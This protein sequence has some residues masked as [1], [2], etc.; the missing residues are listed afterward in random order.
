MNKIP[1]NINDRTHYLDKVKPFVGKNLIKVFTGQRRVGKSYLLFQLIQLLQKDK[2]VAI[3]YINKEDLAFS[4]I[5]TAEDL[6]Q[7]VLENKAENQ[8]TYVFIDEIQDIQNFESALRSLLLYSDLDLYCTGSNANLLSGDIAGHL[9][10]RFIEIVVY[11]LSYVEFLDFHALETSSISVEKYMK[12]GGLPYLK[13]LE[14]E[15]SI[16]FDYLKN[17]YGTIVYRDIINRYSVRNV[18]FLE[19]LVL[20]LAGNIG[21]IFSVKKISDFLKSQQTNMPANQVQIYTH[22]LISA[23]LVHK[24][25]RYDMV[26]KRIFEIGEKYYFENLGIR[27]GIWGYRVEDRGKIVE[28]VVYN[29]LLFKGYTVVVGVLNVCEIDFIAE[30]NGEKH[31]FQ[32]A[33]T[34]NDTKTIEREFGNLKNIKDNYQKTVITLDSFSGNTH[35]GIKTI[36][37]EHFLLS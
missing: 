19:Q 2:T 8:K 25:A 31:Y 22:Y 30:K 23:F 12:Y 28:N 29:Q 24:V 36:S 17:I 21:S 14:L 9:S 27:N 37:L 4:F 1:L 34:I 13:H 6:H 7:Y 18:P 11:S 16:V 15:D 32:V 35:E 3:L 10:G 33:L 20:F 26:G 5:K